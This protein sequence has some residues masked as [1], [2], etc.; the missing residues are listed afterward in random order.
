MVGGRVGQGW[1]EAD[2][3]GMVVDGGGRGRRGWVGGDV[4][5][6]VCRV[7]RGRAAGKEVVGVVLRVRVVARVHHLTNLR[8][9]NVCKNHRKFVCFLSERSLK[10]LD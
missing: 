9:K 8:K 3:V 1:G 4:V 2:P 7:L 6:R 5:G 10:L